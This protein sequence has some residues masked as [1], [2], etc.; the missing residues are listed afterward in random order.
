[1]TDTG[2]L[3]IK[4][5]SL[6]IAAVATSL[7]I[8]SFA[9]AGRDVKSYPSNISVGAISLANHSQ[10][11]AREILEKDLAPSFG[12]KLILKLH[13]KTIAVPLSE[14]GIKYDVPATLKKV[15]SLL[16][17]QESNVL[18][19][20]LMRGKE[21]E[22]S[23]VFSWEK[24]KLYQKLM[25]IKQE[26][27]EAAVDARILYNNDYLEY[28]AHK[29]GFAVNINSSMNKLNSL[30]NEGSLGP[31]EL[32][33]SEIFP[34]V[35]IEDIEAVKDM[36]GVSAGAIQATPDEIKSV[37][38]RWN[39]LIIMPGESFSPSGD[40]KSSNGQKDINSK[41]T[42]QVANLIYKVCSQAGMDIQKETGEVENSLKHP[43]LLTVS[44][45]EKTLLVRLFGCQT[46]P[47]KQIEIISEK[48]EVLPQVIIKVDRRLN[49]QQRVV[50][51]EGKS[52]L[53][54][55]NYRVVM[56]GEKVLE[57]GLLSEHYS[58]AGDTIILVGPGT[59]RK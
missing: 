22:I 39:G 55:R 25:A 31:M 3:G 19:H 46:V 17:S 34:R 44:I 24:E 36:L 13:D 18:Q 47:G 5:I 48:E 15:D 12:D 53:I 57:K 40:D 43:V 30:L 16:N 14:L 54:E 29:N 33:S 21:Q 20:S 42:S 59:V 49:P 11:E 27:D 51:Q 37:L 10:S 45:E 8:V 23:P 2:K 7:I 28:R 9:L 4:V 38:E 56:N 1:M 58:P 41:I 26:N 32:D 35:K 52:G 6:A 50:K